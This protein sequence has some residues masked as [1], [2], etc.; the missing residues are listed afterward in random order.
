M[1]TMFVSQLG[2]RERV[3]VAETV[4]RFLKENDEFSI[5]NLTIALNSRVCDIRETLEEVAKD[6]I[7]EKYICDAEELDT[8]VKKMSLLMLLDVLEDEIPECWN[9]KYIVGGV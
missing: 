9:H 6:I 3:I 2:R 8:T 5:E 1:D 4:T 7:K